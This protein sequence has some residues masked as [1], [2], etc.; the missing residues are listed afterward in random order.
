MLPALGLGAENPAPD[1]HARAAAPSARRSA[2]RFGMFSNKLIVAGIAAEIALILLID[3]TPWG[4]ALFGTA[5]LPWSVWL[6]IIPFAL[7]MLTL[8]DLR[9]WLVR[10]HPSSPAVSLIP[11]VTLGKR[12]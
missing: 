9:K 6:F 1:D 8:E 3:D 11:A 4:N 5:S 10:S 12:L 2:F 7:A